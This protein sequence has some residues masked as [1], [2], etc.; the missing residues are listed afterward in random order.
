[1][2]DMKVVFVV[3][4]TNPLTKRREYWHENTI[5]NEFLEKHP[6]EY[7]TFAEAEY[8]ARVLQAD[9]FAGL[10]IVETYAKTA[11]A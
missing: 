5:P 7:D 3:A 8:R 11:E 4:R 2:S 1:M 6:T 9:G 10:E